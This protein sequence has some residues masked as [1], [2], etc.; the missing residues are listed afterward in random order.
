MV[1]WP[2]STG[3][4]SLSANTAGG[5]QLQRGGMRASHCAM[6][7]RLTTATGTRPAVA[8]R[9]GRPRNAVPRHP[10]RPGLPA[11]RAPAAAAAPRCPPAA[12]PRRCDTSPPAPAAPRAG[13]RPS[14]PAAGSCSS[15][16]G[17]SS[18]P[19]S[20]TA[21]QLSG[22]SSC[23]GRRSSSHSLLAIVPHAFIS[24]PRLRMIGARLTTVPI[25]SDCTGR[26]GH[27]QHVTQVCSWN[28]L[29]RSR[30]HG[31]HDRV[32]PRPVHVRRGKQSP[33][34]PLG[35]VLGR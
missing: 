16:G 15:A 18:C 4:S 22:A 7:S 31:L 8:H 1:T 12:A 5:D 20:S 33:F 30:G 29:V 3:T 32:R 13:R 6:R 28:Q 34:T 35:E 26:I 10:R 23:A 9:A 17:A 27:C 25:A 14:R 24:V 11:R 21:A 19:D 2:G